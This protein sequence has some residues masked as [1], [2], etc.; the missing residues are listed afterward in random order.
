MEL[1]VSSQN[2][3]LSSPDCVSDPDEKEVSEGEDEDD[4][5]NHKHRKQ[6]IHSQSLDGDSLHDGL[7]RP[8]RKRNKPFQNGYSYKEGGLQSGETWKNYNTTSE[9]DFPSRFGKRHLSNQRFRGNQMLG[10]TGLGRGRGRESNSWGPHD[11]RFGLVDFTSQLVQPGPI[12]SGLF[13][14][15]G[16]PNVSNAQSV[17]WNAFGLVPG[18]PNGGLDFLHP[19]GLQG[20]L[21][22][23]IS[24][25]INIGIPR[26]RCRDFEELGFCLRGDM[27]PMEHG[28]NHIVVEDVQSLSQFNLPVSLPGSSS[29]HGAL[30]AR[31]SSS[32]SLVN[33][34]A[35][36]AK[37]SMTR[38][39][40]DGL[41]LNGGSDLYDPD[42]PL[43][44]NDNPETSASLLPLNQSNAD[45]TQSFPYM[46]PSDQQN[47]ESYEGFDDEPPF[48][49]AT[50]AGSQNSS[51]WERIRSSKCRSGLKEKSYS[52]GT[53]SSYLEHNIRSEEPVQTGLPNVPHQGNGTNED[54]E[55]SLKPHG[56]SVRNIQKPSHK[57]LRTLFVNGIPLKD[58]GR[59]A[60]LSHFQKFGE[61]VDIYIPKHS[62][63]A[64][65][66][67]SKR[68]EAEAALKAPDAVMGNRFIKL[69]WANRDNFPNN[70]ISGTTSVPIAQHGRTLNPA[71]SDQFVSRNGKENPHSTGGK[72]GNAHAFVAHVPVYDHPKPKVANGP[73]AP[74][75]QGKKLENLEFLKEELRKKQEMLEQKRNE[76]KRQLDKLEK[77]T[78]GS[79]DD[80]VSNQ[81]TKRL[82]CETPTDHTESETSK[83]L[84]SA[85]SITE[86]TRSTEHGSAQTS[87]LSVKEPFRSSVRP[88]APLGTPFVVNRFKLDNRPTSFRIVSPLP[89][90]LANV[91][92]LEE[93]FSCYGNLSSVELEESKLQE[94]NLDS[95]PSDV[96]ARVSF[97]T[98]PSA[99]KAFLHGKCWQG[100]NLQFTWLKAINSGKEVKISGNPSASSSMPSDS[101]ATT[102]TQK[103]VSLK[104]D[105]VE[106]V[107]ESDAKSIERDKDFKSAST[108][109]SCEK[110]LS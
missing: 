30:P 104:S 74:T 5:R 45:E 55:L 102:N 67:F 94:T 2:P 101:E 19:L 35:L 78:S 12:P 64:F 100:H 24:P 15:R 83:A 8:Y 84:P 96:S 80:L 105:E 17:P 93:H 108:L 89:A 32:G 43:W 63:R 28:I 21:R 20:A 59:E 76:F 106:N 14:G 6:E 107:K 87:T 58:N 97:T 7:T 90:G 54:K 52:E 57:A 27:C 11:S 22:P 37:S 44:T 38:M 34:K 69:W 60:L 71:L 18:V 47:I 61:V 3:G 25:P 77:Q 103:I 42:Q 51:L 1:K 70:G 53:S 91:A 75:L 23:G 16:P 36:H 81:A 92:K 110:H 85:N 72:D 9:R 73:K 68:E 62:E 88:K 29:G 26:Q 10:E 82:K 79:K 31:C 65:V 40:E 99:E 56:D 109:S 95:V 41:G 86:N 4:D 49:T 13:A 39:S 46:D 48:K 66:Q 50:T 98:R 33:S